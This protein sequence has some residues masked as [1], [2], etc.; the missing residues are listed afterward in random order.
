MNLTEWADANQEKVRELTEEV[1]QERRIPREL[2][3]AN[4]LKELQSLTATE[5]NG[6]KSLIVN[7]AGAIRETMEDVEIPDP[8]KPMR[9]EKIIEA[10]TQRKNASIEKIRQNAQAMREA[11]ANKAKLVDPYNPPGMILAAEQDVKSR[12]PEQLAELYEQHAD[13][14][15]MLFHLKRL[16]DPVISSPDT[17]IHAKASYEAAVRK[18]RRPED[19]ERDAAH[20][21]VDVIDGEVQ[22]LGRFYDQELGNARSGNYSGASLDAFRDAILK[23]SS[24][25]AAEQE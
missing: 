21:G 13:N 23:G 10:A 18:H 25:A 6:I 7:S 12:T 14:P 9:V 5:L 11:V 20:A 8:A 1:R 3:M 15:K 16:A 17:S 19:I 22:A 24:R 4:N 2:R